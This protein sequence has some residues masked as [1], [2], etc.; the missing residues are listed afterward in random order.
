MYVCQQPLTRPWNIHIGAQTSRRPD[1][2]RPFA[3]FPRFF[4]P[5][6]LPPS[7]HRCIKMRFLFYL[8]DLEGG[9]G[10]GVDWSRCP[11]DASQ[12]SD[13]L[14]MICTGDEISSLFQR[15]LD[16]CC[17]SEQIWIINFQ[18]GEKRE[19]REKILFYQIKQQ[20]LNSIFPFLL[21][22]VKKKKKKCKTRDSFR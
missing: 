9:E 6:L 18:A 19:W 2:F 5:P 11:A 16:I 14:G 7:L 22:R 10:R 4:H 1:L 13:T 21:F 20:A 15:S 12:A 8:F 17:I 3:T